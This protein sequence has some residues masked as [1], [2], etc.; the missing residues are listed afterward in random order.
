VESWSEDNGQTWSPLQKQALQNPNSGIDAVTTS[1]GLQVLIYNPAVSGADWSDGRN[2][3]RVAVA[4]DGQHWQDVY[5]LEKHPKGE[6]SY[7]AIIQ[8]KD[9]LIHITYTYDRK[10]IKH[11]VLKLI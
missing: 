1:K 7:P 5:E 9:G 10:N 11:V 8:T 4:K 2:E 3:L 6:F